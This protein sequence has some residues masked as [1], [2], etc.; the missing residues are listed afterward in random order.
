M[1]L[2]AMLDDP[3]LTPK[4]DDL[5]GCLRLTTYNVHGCR[6]SDGRLRPERILDVIGHSN[7]EVV[8]LQEL[9]GLECVEFFAKQ[10]KMELFFV[11]ARARRQGEGSYG[12]AILTRLPAML[13]RAASLPRLHATSEARA[14]QW[15][16]VATEFGLVDV[17]NTHLGLLR[18]ETT[19]QADSLLGPDWLSAEELGPYAI[20]CGDFNA[21]PGSPAYRRLCS[22]LRDAQLSA[23]RPLPTFP[24]LFPLVRIDHVLAGRA[25]AV[26]RVHVPSGANA[27]WASDHRPL[28]VDLF[29]A[30]ELAA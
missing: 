28:S 25:L 12:N 24:A 3:P 18:D 8:A 19:L 27:R 16:R 20:L 23:P 14:A 10:L 5:A 2:R 17:L 29:P 26:R 13:V 6:G 11:A 7:S 22:R 15:I 4:L 21:R 1:V 9:D 30:T